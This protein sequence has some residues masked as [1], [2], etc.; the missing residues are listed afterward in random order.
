MTPEESR[1][2]LESISN[3]KHLNADQ[4]MQCN[5]FV[6]C[7][8][9][10]ESGGSRK[11]LNELLQK[12]EVIVPLNAIKLEQKLIDNLKDIATLCKEIDSMT[13]EADTLRTERDEAR[14]EVCK[15]E[16][17]GRIGRF[18]TAQEHA[19]RMGWDCFKSDTLSQ[20]VS[21]GGQQ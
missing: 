9:Y 14:R 20:E 17:G 21:Q 13:K 6:G 15:A 1:N 4:R 11:D 12:Y 19:E 16:S 3:A 7:I 5:M 8:E 18:G 2:Y 10:M